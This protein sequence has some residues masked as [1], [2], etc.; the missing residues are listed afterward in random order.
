MKNT[1]LTLMLLGFLT[2]GCNMSTQK[3]ESSN[4]QTE[5]MEL[6]E[7]INHADSIS[8]QFEEAKNEIDESSK[9]IDELLNDL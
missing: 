8:A 5:E 1:I 4:Q 6:K 9:K 3:E 7:K 2:T